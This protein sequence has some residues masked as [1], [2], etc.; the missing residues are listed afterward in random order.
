MGYMKMEGSLNEEL[1]ELDQLFDKFIGTHDEIWLF[2]AGYYG[3]AFKKYLEE[4]GVKVAGFV[5]SSE[6]HILQN[7]VDR[8]FTIKK[9]KE[10]Y[11]KNSNIGLIVTVDPKFYGEI[12]PKLMFL[13]KNLYLCKLSWLKFA[14]DRCGQ[15]DDNICLIIPIIDYC[16]NIACYGCT[17]CS[18]IA[19]KKMYDFEEFRKDFETISEILEKPIRRINI[20]GG[21]AFIH[22]RLLEFVALVRKRNEEAIISISTSGL[23][24]LEKNDEFWKELSLYNVI[25]D[26]T[27][28]PVDYP[29]Y[30]KLFKRLEKISKTGVKFAIH[31]DGWGENKTSWYLPF[32]MKRQQARDW[33]LCGFHRDGANCISMRDGVLST[34][35]V[36]YAYKQLERKFKDKMSTEFVSDMIDSRNYLR[37]IDIKE[38]DE[39]RKFAV[40]IKPQCS[41]CLIRDRRSMGKWMRSQGKYEEWFADDC[42]SLKYN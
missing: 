27:L 5:V 3:M 41:H 20:T 13:G 4:C 39:I 16:S 24:F 40:S 10:Y 14:V 8:I 9:F 32:T 30:G 23:H 2:G 37:I 26:W 15:V 29:D 17:M 42:D 31:G 18:P 21:E 6:E 33:L 36:N 1:I 19:L 25:I 12:Y 28:Y 7:S 34:C 11:D 22:P 35:C 38:V